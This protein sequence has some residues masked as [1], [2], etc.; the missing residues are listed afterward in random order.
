ME[1]R[2]VGSSTAS[3]WVC[4]RCAGDLSTEVG[5]GE[6]TFPL[7][8][9]TRQA[10]ASASL[11][12][13]AS[14]CPSC[15]LPYTVNGSDR[16]EYP[17]RQLLA[18]AE[19]KNFLRWSAAQNN[20][21]VSYTFLKG[22]SCSVEGRTDAHRFAD[23]IRQSAGDDPGVVLDL[24]CGPLSRPAYLPPYPNATFIGVDPFDSEWTGS[25]I[26]GAG[27][28]LPLRAASVDAV[29]AAT[30]LD[31]TLNL[32]R[33]LTEL[34]RVTRPG[35][36]LVVWD[37]S[38]ESFGAG[39]RRRLDV[40]RGMIART[41]FS[42]K[43]ARLRATFLRERVRVY[44]N[45]IVLWTPK[46]YADPFHEPRSRRRSWPRRLRIA[47]EKAGF[48]FASEDASLGFSHYVRN[49]STGTDRA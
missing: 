37:H 33:A 14:S 25:F 12:Q 24:G 15:G 41:P 19:P 32:A 16:F 35:G 40:L 44:D 28:F 7:S 30:S 6:R 2:H 36:S 43:V 27:E 42:G 45:G 48:T 1:K 10:H 8:I 38:F 22:G 34:A 49:A 5:S 26:Q 20:G 17:Y 4:P 3:L 39:V 47:I 23:F 21:F 13:Y 29:V 11:V 9:N 31:H 18:R 46:G